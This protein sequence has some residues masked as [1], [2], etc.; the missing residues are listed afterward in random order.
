MAAR[1]SWSGH[2]KISLI[3]IPVKLYTV[4]ASSSSKV[5]LNMLHKDCLQRIKQKQTCET[6]GDLSRDDIVKGYEY[7]KGKYVVVDDDTLK[8]IRL[9]TTKI[10]DVDRYIEA[11][12]VDPVYYNAY[13]YV[14]PDGPVGMEAF[15]VLCETLRQ[16]NKVAVGHVVL[17][18]REHTV[19]IAPRDKGLMLTTLRFAKEV[20]KPAS[21]FEDVPDSSVPQEQ[22]D[23]FKQLV[24]GKVDKLDLDSLV[25]RYEEALVEVIK[26]K[27]EGREP[28]VVQEQETAKALDFMEALRKSVEVED[29]P[30]KPP[31]ASASPEEKDSGEQKAG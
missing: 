9:E 12:E 18:G 10:I 13:Y 20:K 26:A 6:H 11:G 17:S 1:A 30:K 21:F 2:L 14:A 31:A 7:E 4:S 5:R 24:E 27:I 3:S 22:V 8:T 15:R 28:E 23:L 19:Q 29:I 16:T 25:D